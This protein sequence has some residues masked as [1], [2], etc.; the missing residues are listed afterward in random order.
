MGTLGYMSPEQLTGGAVD[1]RTD[2]F[3]IGVMVFEAVAGR[4]PFTGS[5]YH[6]LLTNILQGSLRLPGKSPAEMSLG[7]VLRKCLARDPAER[8]SSAAEMQGALIDALRQCPALEELEPAS[9][10]EAETFIIDS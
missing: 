5:N 2:L 7:A 10:A 6:E 9:A 1:Q 8:F 3:S 4:R